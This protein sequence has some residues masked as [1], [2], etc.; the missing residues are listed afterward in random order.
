[1]RLSGEESSESLKGRPH[2]LS[3]EGKRISAGRSNGITRN[4]N[5]GNRITLGG[6]SRLL[7]LAALV[8]CVA[9]ALLFMSPR[10]RGV[11]TVEAASPASGA[12]ATTGPVLPFTGTW[13]GTATGT[14]SAD[15]EATCVEGVNCDSFR[16]TVVPGDYT[17]KIIAVKLQWTVAANDYDLYIHKCPTPAS[18]VAQCNATAPVG[19]DG[20]GA[21]QTQENAAVDPNST[22]A[23]DYTV[24]V[25]YFTTSG[26]ADQYQGSVTLAAS[27]AS[28]TATYVSGGINFSPSVALKAP[29]T[30]RDGEPSNRTDALGNFYVSGI[31][32]FPA[33]VDL[34]YADLQPS[35]GTYDPFMRNWT[36]RGQPDAFSPVSEADLGGD[37]GGDVDLAVSMPDPTTSALPI[38]P[39]LASSSLIAANIS[40]QK[41]TDKGVTYTRNNLG[42][43]SGGIPADDRQWEE[44][45]GNN[46]VYLLYRTL[47]PA[48][49]QIQRSIDGGLTFGPAQTAGQIGQVGYIDVH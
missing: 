17:G 42:N 34:W 25:V 23:G 7:L 43:A 35:S 27:N 44:F 4:R 5:T 26:P 28:R 41:S 36:Y 32:G 19:Q 38:P 8:A 9:A 1:M 40:T 21:P 20:Q 10:L 47:A 29:V 14:G 31:R 11:G 16:L 33:G 24:H 45:Y 46:V 39:T 30:G 6:R 49:T 22:G 15:G 2:R 12:I 48:V 13:A 18:T 3:L 37:G